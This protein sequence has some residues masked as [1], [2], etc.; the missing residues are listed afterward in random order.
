MLANFNE[1]WK[2][3]EYFDACMVNTILVSSVVSIRHIDVMFMTC[4]YIVYVR[5]CLKLLHDVDNKV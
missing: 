5:I 1:N 4:V 3:T 2:S